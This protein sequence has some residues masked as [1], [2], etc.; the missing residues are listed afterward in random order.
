M[1][2]P[3][4]VEPFETDDAADRRYALGMTG[5]LGRFNAA[6]V[7]EAADV[8]TAARIRALADE[9][10][11]EAALA[12]AFVVRQLRHGS[13]CLDLA[14][15]TADPLPEGLAWPAAGWAR[16]VAGSRIGS[17]GVLR[18]EGDRAYLDRYW[19]EECQVRDDLVARLGL[20]PPPAEETT[21][22]TLAPV[23]FPEGYDEQRAAALA[24][25]RAWTT[26]VTGG[27]GTGKTTA[28][29]GLL[30][31]LAEGSERPLRIALTAPTGKAAA[32][33][34]EAVGDAL[35]SE[36]PPRPRG[37]RRTAGRPDAPPAPRVEAGQPQPVP[38]RPSQPPAPRR[39]RG[40]RDVDG[41]A[42]DD[43]PAAGGG[44]VR[45]P[46]GPGR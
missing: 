6:G 9:P 16:R 39:D 11:D 28:I 4:V 43:G 41:V 36:A 15:L 8:H 22:A 32:R 20:T 18:V 44:A 35:R 38:S 5:V 42:D 34:Q 23:L 40:R 7:L 31:L 37:L 29:A 27:P 30:A 14:A 1:T 3:R 17:A 2:T 21:L 24:A 12:L 45:L 25:A 10:D 26:V 46:A 33:L 13:V 19:R